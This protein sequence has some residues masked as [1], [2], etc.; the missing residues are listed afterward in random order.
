MGKSRWPLLCDVKSEHV[1]ALR[2]ANAKEQ[3]F[4]R[5]YSAEIEVFK[6]EKRLT[7]VTESQT[8]TRTNFILYLYL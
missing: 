5:G 8:L 3:S 7:L 2:M 6:M 1:L 4:I